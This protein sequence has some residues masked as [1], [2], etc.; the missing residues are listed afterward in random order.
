MGE[1]AITGKERTFSPDEF[2]VSKTDTKGLITYANDVF[3][4][5]AEYELNEVIG[6]P[7]NIIRHPWMPRCI[8]KLLWTQLKAGKEIFAYVVNRT[9]HG[10]HYW[11]LAHVT[12]SYDA[13]DNLIGFHSSRR[14]PT[15]KAIQA[16]KP[17]YHQLRQLEL[18]AANSKHGM[19]ASMQA[20]Q[21]WVESEG[22][23]YNALIHKI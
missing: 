3:L 12:P 19:L 15:E 1:L 5:M 20:F 9:K 6:K 7:H 10:N 17:L 22:G 2:I 18:N 8:F 23:N 21:Q 11:V 4:E 13:S 16:V 14:A